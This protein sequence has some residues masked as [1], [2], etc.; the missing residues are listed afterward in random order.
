MLELIASVGGSVGA[1]VRLLSVP[2]CSGLEAAVKLVGALAQNVDGMAVEVVN[3]GCQL[4]PTHMLVYIQANLQY[5]G[6]S[7][8]QKLL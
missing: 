6:F 2:Y 3:K 8:E 1:L 5:S 7:R 4:A